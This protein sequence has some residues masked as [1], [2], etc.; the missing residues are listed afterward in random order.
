MTKVPIL[1]MVRETYV[2]L[3]ADWQGPFRIGV[4]WL[5]LA[6]VVAALTWSLLADLAAALVMS[7]GTVAV[8]VAWYRHVLEGV[9]LAGPMAPLDRRA[10]CFVWRTVQFMMLGLI[11]LL[12]VSVTVFL[13][14][15]APSM[16]RAVDSPLLLSTMTA[17]SFLSTGYLGARVQL[18]F[19]AAAILDGEVG[20]IRSWRMTSGNGWRVALG[21]VPTALP[22][23]ATMP[24]TIY[25]SGVA[26]DFGSLVAGT[27]AAIVSTVGSL[28]CAALSASF[29]ARVYRH[30]REVGATL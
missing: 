6:G 3:A 19:P 22:L 5:L 10:L 18:V 8:A 27:L 29:L 1:A 23:A 4:G 25:L 16:E 28:M 24:L 15:G 2:D 21:L 9:P 17:I 20:L 11:V 13:L 14:S 7:L 30:C 26:D 12:V